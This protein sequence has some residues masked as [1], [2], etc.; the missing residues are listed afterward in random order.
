MRREWNGGTIETADGTTFEATYK[1]DFLGRFGSLSE[2]EMAIGNRHSREASERLLEL[3][4]AEEAEAEV[5]A[6]PP[7]Q[8]PLSRRRR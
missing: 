7:R 4:H 2:A 8:S 5:Q 3:R 1:G 6:T